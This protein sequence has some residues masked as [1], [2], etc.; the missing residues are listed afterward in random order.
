MAAVPDDVVALFA[1]Q[2]GIVRSEV[3]RAAGISSHRE[4]RFVD[5]GIWSEVLPGVIS[6][7][8][9]GLDER[10]RLVAAIRYARHPR[11]YLSHATVIQAA[12][13]AEPR[14]PVHVC[15]PHGARVRHEG[16]VVVHQSRYP[17]PALLARGL[18]WSSLPRAVVDSS[19]L[20]GPRDLR[21]LVLDAVHLGGVPLGELREAGKIGPRR[22]RRHLK[23]ALDEVDLGSRSPLEGLAYRE[24]ERAGL[25]LP[26]LNG[27]VETVRGPRFVDL[28]WRRLRFGVEIDGLRYHLV[29]DRWEADLARQNDLLAEGI[30]LLRFPGTRVVHD[31]AGLVAEVAQALEARSS[32]IGVRL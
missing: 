4:A 12:G 1:A 32:E 26:E 15:V 7:G 23:L 11:A 29:R 13:L 17:E 24:I 5:R 18:P 30:V 25:P 20:L 8:P 10:Q 27:R 22:G 6:S 28:L 2:E 16:F 31:L 21:A 3:L 14:E 19:A 9:G